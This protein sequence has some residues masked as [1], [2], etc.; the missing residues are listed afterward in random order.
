M[1]TKL[2]NPFV[3]VRSEGAILPAD[4]LQ[5]VEAGRV[6]D[7]LT[8]EAY[9]RAGEP[10]EP[11]KEGQIRLLCVGSKLCRGLYKRLLQRVG[12]IDSSPQLWMQPDD[13]HPFESRAV[14]RHQVGPG[15][16]V[17]CCS[18][19]QEEGFFRTA[20]Q[21]G[22]HRVLGCAR[23]R[24]GTSLSQLFLGSVGPSHPTNP[25]DDPT[26]PKYID[27]WAG[28]KFKWARPKR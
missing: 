20:H 21:L 9:H 7:G 1:Q 23:S 14:A 18:P 6:L 10:T 24:S 27:P 4:L 15:P 19:P 25:T 16:L 13:D 28:Y 12:R 17:A 3:T 5:W 8:P 11:E 2:K 26:W 22:A